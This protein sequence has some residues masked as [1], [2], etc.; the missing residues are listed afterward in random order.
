MWTILWSLA[1]DPQTI[2]ETGFSAFPSTHSA[3]ADMP[4]GGVVIIMIV[5]FCRLIRVS[6][7]TSTIGG[8]RKPV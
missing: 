4:Y 7:R 1:T 2:L 5:M 8:L 6:L 3:D